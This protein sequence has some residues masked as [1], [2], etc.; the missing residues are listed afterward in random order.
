MLDLKGN[1]I[2]YYGHSTFGLTTP[3]GQVAIIDPWVM[4]NPSV[5]TA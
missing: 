5:R 4:T 1:K 2:T 3:S